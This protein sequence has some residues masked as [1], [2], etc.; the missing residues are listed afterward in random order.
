[1]KLP[2]ALVGILAVSGHGQSIK[3]SAPL[4]RAVVGDVV[5]VRVRADG[6]RVVYAADLMDSGSVQLFSAS[7]VSAEPVLDLGATIPTLF[8]VFELSPDG[9]QVVF[10]KPYDEQGRAELYRVPR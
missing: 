4:A 8:P 1:M 6:R 5:D 9:A 3:L 10:L 2:L 7:L